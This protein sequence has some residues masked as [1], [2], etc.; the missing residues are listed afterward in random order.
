M[1]KGAKFG[2]MAH[3]RNIARLLPDQPISVTAYARLRGVSHTAVQLRIK[4]GT[5]PT[6]AKRINGRW[7]I[8]DVARAD[9]EWHAHTRPWVGSRGG[10]AAGPAPNPPALAEATR[11]E[12]EARANLIEL[13]YER[14]KR[15]L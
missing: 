8:V 15:T 4:A 14:K 5:L 10:T 6:S 7:M 12:R 11:R 2:E 1:V 3:R 9:Q 13:E